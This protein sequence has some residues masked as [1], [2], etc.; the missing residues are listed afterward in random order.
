MN[1]LLQVR[2]RRAQVLRLSGV[3]AEWQA[4]VPGHLY[5]EA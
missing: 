2:R 3:G 5:G 1:G 4:I